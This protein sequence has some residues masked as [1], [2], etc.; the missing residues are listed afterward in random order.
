VIT[1]LAALAVAPNLIHEGMCDGSEP[2]AVTLTEVSEIGRKLEGECVRV[3]G[4][5]LAG[6]L[7]VG[8]DTQPDGYPRIRLGLYSNDFRRGLK[9]IITEGGHWEVT[10]VIDS[11]ARIVEQVRAE[12]AQRDAEAIAAGTL[13]PA[14]VMLGGFCHYAQAPVIWVASAQRTPTSP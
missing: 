1:L 13:R 9:S 5:F 14:P 12:H 2:R 4:R 3:T 8:G 7:V 10:G 11:C 6:A